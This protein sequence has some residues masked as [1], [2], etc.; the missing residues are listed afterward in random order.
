MI[1]VDH[2]DH[3]VLTVHNIQKTCSFYQNVLDMSTQHFEGGRVAL[4]FG[5]EKINLHLLGH[6]IDPKAQYPTPGSADLCF[7]VTSFDDVETT[8]K[9]QQIDYQGPVDRS[10]AMGPITSIYLRDP[11]LNLVELSIY[12]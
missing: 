10:G 7:I 6:E 8:L 4:R 12:R 3:L 11:D 5:Q 9:T 1:K 2:I